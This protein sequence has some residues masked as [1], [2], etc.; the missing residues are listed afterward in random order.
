MA[1]KTNSFRTLI[2]ASGQVAPAS[3]STE[4]KVVAAAKGR[5]A[6]KRTSAEF[7]QVGIYLPKQLHRKAK[8]ALLQED[9][10]RDFSELMA[11]LLAEHLAKPTA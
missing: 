10:E 8:L 1:T 2:A 4:L 11:D 6:G 5:P 9:E 3:P 7:V